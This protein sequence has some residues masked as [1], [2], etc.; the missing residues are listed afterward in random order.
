MNIKKHLT[1]TLALALFLG[2]QSC[3]KEEVKTQTDLKSETYT[4]GFNNG[5]VVASS[6]YDGKHMDNLE[7]MMKVEEVST[8]QST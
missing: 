8:G 4:Y 7:A 6:P 2:T 3:K 5:Q 1:W